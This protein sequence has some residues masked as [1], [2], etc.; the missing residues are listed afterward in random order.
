MVVMSKNTQLISLNENQ[1]QIKTSGDCVDSTLSSLY[2][3]KGLFALILVFLPSQ[4]FLWG[5]RTWGEWRGIVLIEKRP[6]K[7]QIL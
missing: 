1:E 3:L 4:R 6:I 7:G 5:R 2:R